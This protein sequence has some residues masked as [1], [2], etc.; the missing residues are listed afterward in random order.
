MTSYRFRWDAVWNSLDFLMSGLQM[1]L[2]FS[3]P[4][5]GLPLA[6]PPP[7]LQ[8]RP[9]DQVPLARRG[10]LGEQNPPPRHG[11]VVV[12]VPP[13]GDLH[14]HRGRLLLHLLAAGDG[15]PHLGASPCQPIA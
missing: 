15:H 13:A 5:E 3:A 7:P 8:L 12:N 9:A 2:V 11:I 14:L 1:P 4:A 10:H 6:A